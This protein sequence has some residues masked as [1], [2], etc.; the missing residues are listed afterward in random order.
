MKYTEHLVNSFYSSNHTGTISGADIVNKVINKETG[1]AVKLYLIIEDEIIKDAKFQ[2]CGSVVLFASLSAIVDIIIGNPLGTALEITEKHVIKEIKQ[3]NRCDYSMV[4]FAVKALRSTLN[5]YLKRLEKG[6]IN[7]SEKKARVRTLNPAKSITIYNKN[8]N[9]SE[10]EINEP[11]AEMLDETPAPKKEEKVEKEISP[12]VQQEVKVEELEDVIPELEL[13]EDLTPVVLAPVKSEL[14][15]SVP[16]KIEVRILEDDVQDASLEEIEIPEIE[17][18]EE[19]SIKPV[20]SKKG[21]IAEEEPEKNEDVID[22]IDSITAKLTDAITK[23]N[24][25]FDVDDE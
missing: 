12:V 25:K 4:E 21:Y 23:L 20:K 5:T 1:D 10:I 8:A 17:E 6:I 19:E 2:A 15:E 9:K 22:E 3:V 16:T 24:F 7:K 13:E 14:L 11:F 18:P